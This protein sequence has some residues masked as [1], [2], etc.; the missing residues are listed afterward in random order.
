MK[1]Y[2]VEIDGFPMFIMRKE[3]YRVTI[4]EKALLMLLHALDRPYRFHEI[5]EVE[6][7]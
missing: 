3:G 1:I 4:P 5:E 2:V 7:V 6:D